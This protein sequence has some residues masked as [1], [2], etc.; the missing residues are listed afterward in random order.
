MNALNQTAPMLLKSTEK[1]GQIREAR[2]IDGEFTSSEASDVIS[3]LIDAQIN[4]CKIQFISQYE[5]NHETGTDYY[6]QKIA[7][8][9]YKKQ[10]LRESIKRAREEGMK[11][12][13]EG[14]IKLKLGKA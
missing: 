11:I 3:K 1:T 5:G 4:F 12:C 6:E 7:D 8:L 13:I 9:N 2:V 10:E 14:T